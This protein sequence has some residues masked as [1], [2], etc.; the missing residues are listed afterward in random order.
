MPLKNDRH[1]RF[2]KLV[3]SGKPAADSYIK[4]GFRQR[5]AAQSASRLRRNTL[6]A[7]RIAELEPG[8][9]S[10]RQATVGTVIEQDLKTRVGRASVLQARH[11]ELSRFI[12]ERAASRPPAPAQATRGAE[13]TVQAAAPSV[14]GWTTGLI[15]AKLKSLGKGLPMVVEYE[16]DRGLLAELREIERAIAEEL[17][18]HVTKTDVGLQGGSLSDIPTEVLIRW[19]EEAAA[20]KAAEE[21]KAAGGGGQAKKP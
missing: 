9:I 3:A 4:A 13:A 21:A 11:D 5:G 12:A 20:A 15:A 2:A 18:Q 7:N 17:G 1:E 8:F 19:R 16:I 6:V 14:P 10:Q